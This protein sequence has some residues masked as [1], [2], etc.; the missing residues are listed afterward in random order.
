MFKWCWVLRQSL[1]NWMANMPTFGAGS[2][3]RHGR[4]RMM[5]RMEAW[6][7]GGTISI[8]ILSDTLGESN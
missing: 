2:I 1:T 7:D 5:G 8:R 6:D 4:G 3:Q